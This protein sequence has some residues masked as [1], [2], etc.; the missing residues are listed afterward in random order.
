M[1]PCRDVLAKTRLKPPVLHLYTAD[2]LQENTYKSSGGLSHSVKTSLT[3]SLPY[4]FMQAFLI[5]IL[6]CPNH[7][8]AVKSIIRKML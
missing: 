5:C 3:L 6:S 2:Y 4:F 1:K 8:S 7:T